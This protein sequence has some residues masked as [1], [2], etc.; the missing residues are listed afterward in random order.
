MGSARPILKDLFYR[1]GTV[2]LL[3]AV[4]FR[5]AWLRYKKRNA[6]FKKENSHIAIPP[7]YYLY[8]TYLL[9]YQDYVQDGAVTAKEMVE[10]AHV[11]FKNEPKNV[12]EWGCGVGRVV[13]NL[14]GLLPS[15]TG[16][17]GCD[18]NPKMIL[19][20]KENIK[21]VQFHVVQFSPPT[22]YENGFF[23]L[24]YAISVF[25][26]I[27][28]E[29]QDAWLQEVHRILAAGGVFIFTTHGNHFAG[30]LLPQ[31]KEVLKKTGRFTKLYGKKGHRMMSSYND[32][33]AF[34]KVVTR[35]FDILE[36][37][38]GAANKSKIGGQDLWIV[39]KK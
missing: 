27:D 21:G 23:D 22:H 20:D 37:W 10:W 3:D 11:Y 1:T 19:W 33:V 12:L 38:D 26:H 8:E 14:P 39:K 13:R 29:Q 18:I 2:S 7:D 9:S 5:L 28:V 16:I 4:L 35:Y 17:Y 25:T 34:G 32:A 15:A 36:F 24:I 30:N 6:K 31:E